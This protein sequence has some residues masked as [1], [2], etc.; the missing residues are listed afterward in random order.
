MIFFY[1]LLGT[2]FGSFYNVI[3]FRLPLNK[4]II[5]P[6]SH[7]YNCKNIIPFYLNIPIISFIFCLGKCFYCK[8]K[9]SLQYPLIEII[10]GLYWCIAFTTFQ[11]NEAILFIWMSGI[12]TIIASIDFK[13]Y[14][15]PTSLI[16]LSIFGITAYNI[17][18]INNFIDSLY[19]LLFGIIYL[20]GIALISSILSKKQTLGFGDILLIIVLGA[21]LGMINIAITIFFSSLIALI[22]WFFI[23]FKDGFIKDRKLPFGFYLSNVSIWVYIFKT[24][25]LFF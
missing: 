16:I 23:S 11:I 17:I 21:W 1:F 15:I 20:G 7:C 10:T 9:I 24:D 14:I 4:S 2:I 3:I 6:R 5:S 19:G 25:N 18:S 13:H 8:T 22:A 12:L